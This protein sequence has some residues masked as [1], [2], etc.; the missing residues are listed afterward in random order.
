MD[1]KFL[2]MSGEYINVAVWVYYQSIMETAL[3]LLSASD[4]EQENY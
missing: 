2:N 3:P 4:I 1:R